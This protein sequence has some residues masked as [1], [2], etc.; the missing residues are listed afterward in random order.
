MELPTA[1]GLPIQLY[2]TTLDARDPSSQAS[3]GDLDDDL[4]DI[5]MDVACGLTIHDQGDAMT[6]TWY[7]RLMFEAHWG[8][9]AVEALRVLHAIAY[10]PKA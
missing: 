1:F 2:S 4:R 6:A 5:A 3:C 7:W 8:A 10:R 9:H